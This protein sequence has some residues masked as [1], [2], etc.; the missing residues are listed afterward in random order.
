MQYRFSNDDLLE[1]W[2]S[3]VNDDPFAGRPY[4]LR[5]I[6][7]DFEIS[8]ALT[9][10]NLI[11]ASIPEAE[12]WRARRYQLVRS[13]NNGKPLEHRE[14]GANGYF[15]YRFT[16]EKNVFGFV[17]VATGFVPATVDPLF[18]TV[19]YG[20]PIR[21][22]PGQVHGVAHTIRFGEGVAVPMFPA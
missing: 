16:E 11:F 3:G 15:T 17:W 14:R 22:K 1:I 8:R 9:V 19:K 12:V 4:E 13:L 18:I 5:L 20:S 2:R 10:S 6:V 7:A 21:M